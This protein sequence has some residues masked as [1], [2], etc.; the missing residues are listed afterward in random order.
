MKS[1]L[2]ALLVLGTTYSWALT[3]TQALARAIARAEGFYAPGSKPQRFHNPGDIRASRGVHYD[4][5]IS[6]DRQ[7]YV[8]FRRDADG[9]AA[10]EDQIQRILDGSSRFYSVN[11]T[12]RQ[13]AK[14]YA[15]SPTWAKNVASALRCEPTAPLWE[16]L[17]T[18]PV[19]TAKV[20]SHA[21]ASLF[22]K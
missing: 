7:G 16:V 2:L 8:I 20:D 15:T 17:G 9:W 12:L 6:T 21:L 4:G 1:L 14:R 22:S 3:P 19:V 10:L 5:Q 13:L 11:N 18:A